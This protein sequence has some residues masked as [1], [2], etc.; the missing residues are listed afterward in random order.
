L[1]YEPASFG[2]EV[3]HRASDAVGAEL[4][5]DRGAVEEEFAVA[6]ARKEG[7]PV[8]VCKR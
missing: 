2:P 4:G 6:Q 8:A 1:F 7:E 3:A 5:V